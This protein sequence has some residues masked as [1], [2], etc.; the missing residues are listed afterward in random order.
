M[1]GFRITHVHQSHVRKLFHTTVVHLHSHH[2]V[3]PVGN[4]QRILEITFVNKVA[5]HKGRTAFL[6][7]IRQVLDGTLQIG[8]LTFRLEI[9]QFTNDIQNMLAALLGRDKFLDTVG[10][11]NHADFII[12][13]NGGKGDC[14]RNLRHHF[15][16][17]LLNGTKVQTVG[18]V[19]Q[20]HD[21]K[22]TFFL[23][24]FHEWFVEAS[25]HI[26]VNIAHVIPILILADL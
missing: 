1:T 24:D 25:G 21:R 15:F 18:H 23:K 13:L 4:R 14:S 17:Q 11:E 5:Q 12:V 19:H 8:A 26:P 16:L 10:K 20:Q 3:F 2:I 22:F 6:Q 9:K 7:H